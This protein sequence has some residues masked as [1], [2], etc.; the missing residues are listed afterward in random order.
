MTAADFFASSNVLI[1]AGKGG[2]GK[3][4]V[5]ATLGI[6][7]A[8]TGCDVLLV[9]LEGHSSLGA[10]FGIRQLDYRE[11]ELDLDGIGGE[12]RATG[13][14]RAR[15]LKPDVALVEYLDRGGLGA[16]AGR[17]SRSGAIEVV[18]TAAPGI[19][20]LL[21]LG[22]IRQIEQAGAA[23]LII[24][25]APAAGHAITFLTAAGGLASST[26]SGPIK[27]QADMVL[28]MFADERRCR[29]MLVALPEETPVSEL[30][31]TAYQVEDDV[32]LKL[33][34]VV[35]NGVWPDVPGLAEAVAARKRPR[36]AERPA[37]AAGRYRLARMEVQ[38]AEIDRLRSE[39]PLP[40][41]EL[42]F[43]FRADLGRDELSELADHMIERLTA[44]P[45]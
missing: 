24:V 29:V 26:S 34:P 43:L 5:G 30:I 18:A 44:V 9:E 13:R 39:L 14:L 35:I 33:G 41:V 3:T 15:Q 22:K 28:E 23:D 42:P 31:E 37:V 32:G 16:V 12:H 38:R 6:A 19:R 45:A 1:V 40:Q 8:R 11:I 21:T 2:V 25:D 10:S 36:V 17:F 27:D 20:D 7:A 4:T